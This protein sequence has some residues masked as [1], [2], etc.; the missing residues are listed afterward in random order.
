MNGVF[1]HAAA[2][3]ETEHVGEGTRIWA[4]AHVMKDVHIGANCNIGD[5]CFVE[6][7]AT[8]GND[9]TLKNGNMIWAGVLL[10]DGVFVGPHVFFTNDLYP[11][12]PR[13]PQARKRYGDSKWMLPTVV[14][15]G[16]TLGAGAVILAGHVIGEFSMVGAGA[17]VTKDVPGYALVI[18]NAARVCGW[19]C[20]CGHP[21]EFHNGMATCCEC[22]LTLVKEGESVK[23]TNPSL[24]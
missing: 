9:V 10:E 21:L 19:V 3:V 7:G 2:L 14:R 4:F 17:V 5:H 18:G 23:P 6:T 13:L 15:R 12:S 16:A 24:P 1:V 8:I 20:Q 22:N 11:R